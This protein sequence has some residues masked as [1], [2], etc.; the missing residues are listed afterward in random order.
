MTDKW[1]QQAQEL[2]ASS[3]WKLTPETVG[4]LAPEL[5]V[6][7]AAAFLRAAAEDRE[8]CVRIAE[9]FEQG[10]EQLAAAIRAAKEPSE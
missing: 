7:L 1:D 9:E 3:N 4:S 6:S 5:R 10:V 8:R 2:L